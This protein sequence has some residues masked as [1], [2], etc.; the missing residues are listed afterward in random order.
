MVRHW[1]FE[2]GLLCVFANEASASGVLSLAAAV[3]FPQ[4]CGFHSIQSPVSAP[5]LRFMRPLSPFAAYLCAF[6]CLSLLC[7]GPAGAV[8]AAVN[9]SY[10]V[11]EDTPFTP[12][13]LAVVNG[14]FNGGADGFTYTDDTFGTNN[15]NN[16][17]G[18]V[19]ATRG[20]G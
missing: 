7:A 9:H 19:N 20:V 13:G 16:A 11:T 12:P 4:V 5:I 6:V 8:P 15:P 14:T 17:T 3:I 10:T 2:T 1:P 18:S